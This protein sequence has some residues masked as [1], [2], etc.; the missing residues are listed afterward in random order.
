MTVAATGSVHLVGALPDGTPL[1]FTGPLSQSNVLSLYL[2]LNFRKGA[3]AGTVA[4][5]R[6]QSRRPRCRGAGA[7]WFRPSN[8]LALRYKAGWPN[9]IKLDLIAAHYTPPSVTASVRVLPGLTDPDANGNAGVVISGTDLAA[10]IPKSL[11]ITAAGFV[12]VIDRGAEKLVFTIVPSDGTFAG[13]FVPA[14]GKPAIPYKGVL[15]QKQNRGAGFFL[16]ATESGSVKLSL[17]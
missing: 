16:G 13:S 15:F 17:Q 9:G 6:I 3:L 10:S 7:R 1:L 12:T 8:P 14:L 4:F 5:H 2:P 11:N